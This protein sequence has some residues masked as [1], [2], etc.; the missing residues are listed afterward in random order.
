MKRPAM[1]RARN[2]ASAAVLL[3]VL[4]LFQL[5][6]KTEETRKIPD[7]RTVSDLSTQEPIASGDGWEVRLGIGA[8]GEASGPWRL[9]YCLVKQTDDDPKP[10]VDVASDGGDEFL[11]PVRY[12]VRQD[13]EEYKVL[14]ELAR[15]AR[16]P[17][18]DALYC[19]RILTAWKGRYHVSV[20]SRDGK[21][22][23]ECAFEI[24]SPRMCYWQQ[25]ACV[26]PSDAA[27][28]VD[29]TV[30]DRAY[31]AVPN[32]NRTMPI[33]QPDQILGIETAGMLPLPGTVP[34]DFAWLN[35]IAASQR[36]T[37]PRKH[38]DHALTLS[39]EKGCFVLNSIAPMVN[40]PD[41]L[42]LARWWVNDHPIVPKVSTKNELQELHRQLAPTKQF[43]MAAALP[44]GLGE[45]KPG[46]KI[47]VQLLYSPTIYE[48]LPASREE[49]QLKQL[50]L[51]IEDE[52]PAIPL[53]SNRLEFEVTPRLLE[54]R[55]EHRPQDARDE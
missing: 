14:R 10:K 35:C 31:A 16:L 8:G 28:S 22:L 39:F 19:G 18:R 38:S 49:S 51:G 34:V 44:L 6:G 29:A 13:G 53:I 47:G 3:S 30:R 27:A 37:K 15:V 48:L 45:L 52:T 26:E 5:T 36:S 11:G 43:E 20:F 54:N 9:L 55:A 33:W 24:D 4:T 32:F 25:F 50:A 7:V 41:R 2:F 46:D 17:V 23:A 40:W 1:D 12:R 42:L 21:L